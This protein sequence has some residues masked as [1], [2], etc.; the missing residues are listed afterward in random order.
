MKQSSYTKTNERN[1]IARIPSK[2]YSWELD[3]KAMLGKSTFKIPPSELINRCCEVLDND[4]GVK[5]PG[6]LADDFTFQFPIIGPLSKT[7]YLEAVS[8]FDYSIYALSDCVF[9]Y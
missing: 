8:R 5:E 7:E 9:V 6:D 4:V 2:K 1:M 3:E